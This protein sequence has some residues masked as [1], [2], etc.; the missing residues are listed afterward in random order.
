MRR[1]GRRLLAAL[2][3]AVLAAAPI[4]A[5]RSKPPEAPAP[6]APT[7]VRV[8][9]QGFPDMDIYVLDQS[10]TRQRLGTVTGSSTQVLTIPSNL[11]FGG[12]T[13]RFI[14]DPVGARRAPVSD[15][16]AVRPGDQVVLTIPPF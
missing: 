7:T 13:L 8:E 12:A 2:L 9:N 14:A 4:T 10:G 15:Q 5:C 6:N 3:P 1:H 16:I 11:V